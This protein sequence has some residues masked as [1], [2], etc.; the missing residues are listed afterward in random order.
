MRTFDN[1]CFYTVQCTERDVT[2]FAR[3]WPCFGPRVPI[4]FQFDKRNGGL[5]DVTR[6]RGAYVARGVLGLS[7]GCV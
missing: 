6:A 7:T 4:T 1:G 5:V 3:R 2:E